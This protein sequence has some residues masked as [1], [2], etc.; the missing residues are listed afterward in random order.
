M[1]ASSCFRRSWNVSG[2]SSA[3]RNR[4]RVALILVTLPV[5]TA[6]FAVAQRSVAQNSTSDPAFSAIAAFVEKWGWTADLGRMCA[7]FKLSPAEIE[8][9]YKQV[10][11]AEGD[12]T[13]PNH[14]FN[15]PLNASPSAPHVVL[16]H[17]RP[18]VGTFFVVSLDG[19]LKASFYRAP[20]ADYTTIPDDEAKQ[21]FLAEIAFWKKNLPTLEEMA[22]AGGIKR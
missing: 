14:G 8:C 3:V 1:S 17:L 18:L 15:L 22:K 21:A 20:G 13:L 12:G 19:T 9:K 7:A 6:V 11:V 4:V 10:A 2:V 5:A 16:Y